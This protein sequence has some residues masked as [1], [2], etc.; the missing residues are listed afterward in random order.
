MRHLVS[1]IFQF[2]WNV[3]FTL[4]ASIGSTFCSTVQS[5]DLPAPRRVLA[6]E[7][8]SE[9][10]ANKTKVSSVA[11][12]N[13]QFASSAP[14]SNSVEERP[15]NTVTNK[16][17]DS[18]DNQ[19]PLPVEELKNQIK[20][21]EAA[22]D[23]VSALLHCQEAILQPEA[24]KTQQGLREIEMLKFHGGEI[25][26]ERLSFEQLE[27]VSPDLVLKTFKAKVSFRLGQ[28][29]LQAREHN[30]ARDYFL[31]TLSVEP[32]S[33]VAKRAQE[34]LVQV[35]AVQRVNP[36]TVGVVLPLTGKYASVAQ[37]TLRGI[38]MGLG[39]QKENGSSFRLAVV[40]SEGNSDTAR[41]GVDRL[42]MED[43]V[44]AVIGSVLSKTATGVSSRCAEYG[45]PNIT[46][47]QKIGLT[48]LGPSVFR[49]A[50]T[51]EMQVNFL[52]KV[53]MENLGLKRFALLYPNDQYGVEYAN[54]FWDE[55]LARGGSI[56]SAQSYLP[57]ETDFRLAVQRL[58]GTFYTEDRGEEY[59]DR[60]KNW[61]QQEKKKSGRRALGAPPEDFLPP[62]VDFDAIFIPDGVKSMGQIAAMLAYNNVRGVKLL[63]TN[64]W[65]V[66]GLAKRAGN[67]AKDVVF[68]DSFTPADPGFQNSTFVKEY[69][70]IFGEEPGVFEVQGYDS[71]FVLRQLIASGSTS[72]EGLSSALN[73]LRS[74]Q[75]AIGTASM[76]TER[77]MLRPI[78]AFIVESGDIVPMR[79]KR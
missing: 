74:V 27:G 60:L 73:R 25:I 31:Q 32:G 51:S 71:A 59:R 29:S 77:E 33:D 64:L 26:E 57:K 61:M 22:G 34:A 48:E 72:R 50:L 69:K 52:V 6:R 4:F 1:F 76:T 35:E 14:P 75:L 68:V 21:D 56:S 53:A 28:V 16:K 67:S 18:S 17:E 24:S 55:V 79:V 54:I 3:V 65:N 13:T 9:R 8:K 36:K 63:G 41:K 42:I 47:S 11:M 45:V 49:N 30:K 10:P 66:P 7:L 12:K 38:Q 62:I 78:K 5:R 23:Y 2:P 44:I 70:T 20:I 15:A 58:V 37:K 39:L 46:L 40:D 43:N 19:E